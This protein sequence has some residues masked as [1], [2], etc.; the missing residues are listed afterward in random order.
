MDEWRSDL[1]GELRDATN[2]ECRIVQFSFSNRFR[3]VFAFDLRRGWLDEFELTGLKRWKILAEKL[4][5]VRQR[6][7]EINS[8]ANRCRR[9]G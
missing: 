2:G 9:I 8:D 3:L 1:L 7:I 5:H 6:S 4:S